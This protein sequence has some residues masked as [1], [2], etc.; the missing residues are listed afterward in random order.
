MVAFFV[1]P[2]H[3]KPLD[4]KPPWGDIYSVV[5][6]PGLAGGATEGDAT[7]SVLFGGSGSASTV[8]RSDHNHDGRYLAVDAN[9]DD[10]Y[11][12]LGGTFDDRYSLLGHD[13]DGRY[14]PVDANFDDRYLR[15]IGG[16]LSGSL[17]V[18]GLVSTAPDG[19]APFEVGSGTLVDNLN[20][21]RLDGRDSSEFALT[22]QLPSSGVYATLAGDNAFN[23]ANTFNAAATFGAPVRMTTGS[24]S[25]T[26]QPFFTSP[27]AYSLR[28]IDTFAG[29]T[30][31]TLDQSGRLGIGT[32]SPGFP[33]HV[34]GDVRASGLNL[35]T[36]VL[37]PFLYDMASATDRT[38]SI[39]NSNGGLGHLSVEGMVSAA[40]FSI[41]TGGAGAR[42]GNDAIPTGATTRAVPTTA[43]G[44]GSL[45]FVTED[46]SRPGCVHAPGGLYVGSR[47]AGVSFTVSTDA[48]APGAGQSYCFNWWVVN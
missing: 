32:T 31:L 6:G 12:R 17:S 20:A 25:F 9:F 46:S 44:A 22:S 42:A 45:I 21:D 23:G 11:M 14:L 43:V 4:P 18:P 26:W 27:T 29:P 35:G 40:G 33:L 34:V 24:A 3:A 1:A 13:H 41:A 47:N 28:L 19:T 16:A 48:S 38:L 37:T 5:A 2:V 8:A 30:R 36:A 10:R 15:L 7:L 39:T